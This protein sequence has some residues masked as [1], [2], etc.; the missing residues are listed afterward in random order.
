MKL[1]VIDKRDSKQIYSQI[2]DLAKYYV[3]QW[4]TSLQEDAGII[5]SKIYSEMFA[6][7]IQRFNK[8]PYKN[9]IYFL[10]LLGADTL[11]SV[12]ARGYI[13]IEL[14]EGATQGVMIKRGTH[15]YSQNSEGQRVLFE[16]KND[17]YAI[18]NKVKAV[19]CKNDDK[20]IIVKAYAEND[21]SSSFKLFDFYENENLQKHRV[22]FS[23]AEVLNIE[24]LSEISVIIRHSEKPYLENKI[25]EKLSDSHCTMWEYLTEDGWYPLEQAR[26]VANRVNITVKQPI[27]EVFYNGAISRWLS[28]R[29]INS[30]DL[31]EIAFTDLRIC[32]RSENILPQNLY[33]NDLALLKTDFLPFNERYSSYDTFYINSDEVFS[34][35]G[36]YITVQ[37]TIDFKTATMNQDKNQFN[38]K[39]KP[40]LTQ[41]DITPPIQYDID[42]E[43]V[44]WEYWN[45][46]GWARLFEHS[47]YENIFS[48][49]DKKNVTL[50]FTG[51]NDIDIT[52]IGAASGMWI[53]AR[54]LNINNVFEANGC[55]HYPVIETISLAYSYK[56]ELKKVERILIER[57]CETKL[58]EKIDNNERVVYSKDKISF[59]TVYFALENPIK[60][61]PIKMYFKKEGMDLENPA[62]LKWEYYGKSNGSYRWIE[63]KVLDETK[64]LKHSGLVTF[65]CT[66]V[67]EKRKLFGQ[68]AYWIR[69]VNTDRVYGDQKVLLP[70]LSG[71]YFNTVKITQKESIQSEYFSIDRHQRNKGCQL[72]YGNLVSQ[73]VW[74]NEMSD[75]LGE[76][77]NDYHLLKQ[78]DAIIEKDIQ[79]NITQYWVKWE[80]TINI[81]SADALDRVYVVDKKNG[82]IVF[83]DGICGK[84]PNYMESESIRV[85]YCITQG[86]KGNFLENQI[87]GFSD[88]VPFVNRVYNVE[89]VSGGCDIE[90]IAEAIDRSVNTIRYQDKA[91]AYD[92]YEHLVKQA[93]R[94][95]AKVKTILHMTASGEM[96]HGNVTIVVLPNKINSD[97]GYFS[98]IRKNVL[99]SLKN[100]A[101][102]VLTYTNKI[103]VIEAEYV[104]F[105]IGVD[106]TIENYD[107]YQDVY[108]G[109]ENKLSLFLNPIQGNFDGKGFD[110]GLLPNKIKIYNYIKTI[111]DI[112]SIDSIYINCYKVV[113]EKRKEIDY[114]RIFELQYAV[115]INGTHSIGINV[116]QQF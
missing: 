20:D 40:I 45:G 80:E 100:K 106:V 32:S 108:S 50:S 107:N 99:E 83:G 25:A 95:I 109:I 2:M 41:K 48:Q 79:G 71:I 42:I 72:I 21:G 18:D 70:V 53:R 102:A 82:K 74:V 52:S 28:I 73:N 87:K 115:P 105:C 64:N 69:L 15:L 46:I 90:T 63:L 98:N 6:Q 91:V 16:T 13:T 75:L 112:K 36:A 30:E 38:I 10:N 84:I 58:I 67:F 35:R 66:E 62:T 24:N 88:P 113:R 76:A 34:K 61:G 55:Y 22:I 60:Q 51:P 43:K 14:N 116:V 11:P 7:T 4:N 19:Y 93:D 33:N 110:I 8:M 9:F 29:I 77:V 57:D 111:E 96:K 27:P 101:P 54:I 39:W 68:Q 26:A 85:D 86:S 104:E 114:D 44:I 81:K 89:S 23:Q 37:M 94:N 49:R 65:S 1:P 17:L 31:S 5:L 103:E 92:D 78:K 12:S 56:E 3:P 97:G 59:P 47:S